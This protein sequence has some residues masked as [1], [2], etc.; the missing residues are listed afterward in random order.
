MHLETRRPIGDV[1]ANDE[2]LDPESCMWRIVQSVAQDE[3]D[4][5]V[6]VTFTDQDQLAFME[7]IVVTVR[8]PSTPAVPPAPTALVPASSPTPPPAPTR[9][10][11]AFAPAPL[12]PLPVVPTPVAS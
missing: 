8:R 6:R 2:V 11:P 12:P 3:E 7:G 9:A 4:G 10:P 1:R 5:L